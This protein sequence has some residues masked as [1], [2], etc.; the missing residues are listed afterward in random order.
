M[1]CVY[2]FSFCQKKKM[3]YVSLKIPCFSTRFRIFPLSVTDTQFWILTDNIEIFFIVIAQ[4]SG[5]RNGFPT[6][7]LS[8]TL[9]P[10]S[11][12]GKIGAWGTLQALEPVSWHMPV[13]APEAEPCELP[14]WGTL[15]HRAF[16]PFS[17]SFT[18]STC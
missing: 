1:T 10:A 3:F 16:P 14:L 7:H 18:A 6:Q 17:W 2:R 15:R 4:T 5:T 9:C 11:L 8:S 13:P 12:R